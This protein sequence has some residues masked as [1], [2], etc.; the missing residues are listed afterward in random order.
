MRQVLSHITVASITVFF[1]NVISLL[2][3]RAA[4]TRNRKIRVKVGGRPIAVRTSAEHGSEEIGMLLPGAVVTV[5]EE[6]IGR[7]G[8][9]DACVAL[10]FMEKEDRQGRPLGPR[11]PKANGGRNAKSAL[12]SARLLHFAH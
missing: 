8:N 12:C 9:V 11:G 6:R 5:V 4:Q 10:D 7:G 1:A 2:H 3:A